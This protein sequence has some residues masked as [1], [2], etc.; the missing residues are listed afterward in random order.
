MPP[1]A[2]SNWGVLLALGRSDLILQ[3]ETVENVMY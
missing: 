2:I 1:W 3:L